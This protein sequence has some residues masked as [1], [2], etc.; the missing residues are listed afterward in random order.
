MKEITYTQDGDTI[1]V[2]VP[3]E[4]K[5]EFRDTFKT[6]KWQSASKTWAVSDNT[7]NQ[8]KVDQW[9][10]LVRESSVLDQ[11]NAGD[12]LELINAQLNKARTQ[13]QTLSA[14]MLSVESLNELITERADEIRAIEEQVSG[15]AQGGMVATQTSPQAVQREATAEDVIAVLKTGTPDEVKAFFVGLPI[16]QQYSLSTSTSI[17][18]STG[19]GLAAEDQDVSNDNMR[20]LLDLGAGLNHQVDTSRMFGDPNFDEPPSITEAASSA[21]K[22]LTLLKAGG[23]VTGKVHVN[24]WKYEGDTTELVEHM[25][26]IG[27]AF[28]SKDLDQASNPYTLKALIAQGADPSDDKNEALPLA[29]S[30]IILKSSSGCLDIL[31]AAGLDTAVKDTDGRTVADLAVANSNVDY[32]K[33]LVR[34]GTDMTT[35]AHLA[36]A[37]AHIIDAEGVYEERINILLDAGADPNMESEKEYGMFSQT[38]ALALVIA[39]TWKQEIARPKDLSSH[40]EDA[41][42]IND[43]KCSV[44]DSLIKSGADVA[45]QDQRGNTPLHYAVANS[46]PLVQLLLD[47]GADPHAA[48]K[49]GKT[50]L[51]RAKEHT[52]DDV[53]ALMERST[54]MKSLGESDESM[55]SVERPARQRKM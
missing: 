15:L 1:N 55:P 34:F 46:A 22:A 51:D 17:I 40:S 20:V 4:L 18:T 33:S 27:V 49:R 38:N 48:N 12:E 53:V 16:D 54:I 35:G 29:H 28:S 31:L 19:L 14:K 39:G 32:L 24:M 2:S 11:I 45:T 50:A 9:I 3:F 8:N 52:K 36:R 25:A 13:L 5:D 21:Q 7:R 26:Q 42:V 44:V 6:A 47:A 10:D 23:D 37:A 30:K 43:R 41:S